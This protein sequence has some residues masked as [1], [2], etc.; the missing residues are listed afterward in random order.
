MAWHRTYGL[1]V[2]LSHSSNT[3]GPGQ[4]P[5]KL[6]PSTIL[7]ALAERPIPVYGAGENVRDW[8]FVE[9]HARVLERIFASGRVGQS[10]PVGARASRTNIEVVRSICRLLDV[11]RPRR[12]GDPYEL[13]IS[14]VADRPGHDWRYAIDPAK[15][16]T[17]LGWRPSESFESG[18]GKTVDWY[19][20][21]SGRPQAELH[22]GNI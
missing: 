6:I 1:P 7:H 17:E 22:S 14:F 2:V 20:A 5:D 19:L 3:Y 9:D 21:N 12:C 15:T 4:Y 13:L 10:Y 16:Q 11:R 8:I 18:L